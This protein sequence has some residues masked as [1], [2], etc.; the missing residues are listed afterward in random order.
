VIPIGEV[1]ARLR[2]FGLLVRAVPATDLE[3]A[4]IS[5]DSRDVRAGDLYCAV[6]GH[7]HD[8]HDYLKDAAEAGAV[9]ALVEARVAGVDL[10]QIEV[11]DSRR[12]ASIAAQLVYGDPARGLRLVGVTGTNGKTTTVHLARHVLS[13]RRRVGSLGTLGAVAPTGAQTPTPLTTPGPV[14][15]ARRLAELREA[16][17][18]CVVAEVSS[19]ALAQGRVDGAKFDV[20]VFTNLSR[21]HLDYHAD[22]DAYRAAK[23]RLADLLDA[24]GVLVVNADEAAWSPLLARER[25]VRFGLDAEAEYAV[26]GAIETTGRGT[27]WTLVT[28]EGAARVELPLLGEFNVA[29]ALAAAA[30]AATLGL[31]A[32]EIAEA[33]STAPPV[34]GRLE[35]LAES[36][37]VLRDYAH[38]PDALRRALEAVRPFVTGR[39]IVV[40]GCG[41]DRDPG[42]RPLM[43]RAAAEGADLAIVTSD[44]PRTEPP[45][46]IVAAIVPGVG[47]APHEVIVDRREAIAR[48]LELAGPNDAVLLAGKGHETYQVVGTERRPF[49]EAVIVGELLGEREAGA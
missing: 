42:K 10:P 6:R 25:V 33:L 48:A 37:L 18:D 12:A 22:F 29:N 47:D 43:G 3:V 17:A 28:P 19:H 35:V 34:P 23:L 38:T 2:S 40:F 4:G 15:F 30:V 5:D 31:T 36:P 7:V 13:R 27:S 45:E 39:L 1:I 26:R 46:G 9:A 49:D 32:A 8:G 44:N 16:G 14:E 41:G 24:D 20:A 21:D 11:A